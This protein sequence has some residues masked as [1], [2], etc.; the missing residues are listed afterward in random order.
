M[1]TTHLDPGVAAAGASGYLD[2]SCCIEPIKPAGPAAGGGR[3]GRR[4]SAPA[5]EDAAANKAKDGQG[6]SE[7]EADEYTASGRRKR[8]DAGQ[9][10]A[11][12]VSR[13]WSDEEE[14]LFMEV[15]LTPLHI[16]GCSHV[17]AVQRIPPRY[18]F[19]FSGLLHV[20]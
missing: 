19:S 12:G 15:D 4:K 1:T 9:Q 13:G 17:Q 20:M 8:K 3:G 10:G 5:S 6:G 2:R 7:Q 16:L 14:K 11:R 18:D